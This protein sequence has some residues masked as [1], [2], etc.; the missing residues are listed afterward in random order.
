MYDHWE[1]KTNCSFFNLHVS[2]KI[3]CQTTADSS[4]RTT[5]YP[6]KWLLRNEHRNSILKTN[7]YRDLG[8][9]ASHWSCCMGNLLQLITST[10]RCRWW[11]VISMEFLCSFLLFHTWI[12]E[13]LDRELLSRGLISNRRLA[14]P[15]FRMALTGSIIVEICDETMAK[16]WRKP[17]EM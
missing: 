4:W 12:I 10:P 8:Y 3:A 11:R 7:G 2:T 14:G 13:R 5:A 1:S 6:A 17:V 9:R 15:C 16:M